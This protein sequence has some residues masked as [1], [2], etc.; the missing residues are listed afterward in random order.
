MGLKFKAKQPLPGQVEIFSPYITV[1]GRR[2][3]PKKGKVF[4]FF[5]YPK[6]KG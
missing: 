6:K 3:Y 1:K 4:H 2:V 5:A